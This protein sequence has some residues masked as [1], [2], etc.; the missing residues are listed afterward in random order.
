MSY[1]FRIKEQSMLDDLI[2]KLLELDDGVTRKL[3]VEEHGFPWHPVI[4][5]YELAK[6]ADNFSIST[7]GASYTDVVPQ[8]VIHKVDN[9]KADVVAAQ[10]V[11]DSATESAGS[12]VKWPDT[13]VI[14]DGIDNFIKPAFYDRMA[15]MVALGRHISIAGPPGIGKSTAIE[16][17]AAD[18]NKPM[19]HISADA[20][21]RR[22]DLTGNVELVNSHT[23]FMVAQ[24][25]AAAVFGWWVKIDEVN[26]AEPDALM[27]LNS[28]MAPPFT[29]NFYG[30]SMLV[31]PNFRLFVTYN[32][33]LIGTKPLPPA[34]K[35]RFFSLKMGF[36][37][38]YQ[39]R[40]LLEAN[41][42]PERDDGSDSAWTDAVIAYGLKAWEQHEKGRMRY[43][44]TPRRLMDAVAL[45]TAAGEDVF[46]AL[47]A[48]VIAAV[49]N[50]AEQQVLKSTLQDVKRSYEFGRLV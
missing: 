26:A 16:Q 43:Q 24:Y 5:A 8:T 6:Y 7:S 36:P 17:L 49:D 30:T 22:R 47:E 25:V 50:V 48:A 35:D 19:V 1:T 23:Q 32:P 2:T 10:Q 34:F 37:S 46:D 18:C 45:V 41:G 15:A 20:G 21:L 14:S 38:E 28:Q 33:G 42:M 40:R 31:H 27:F 39:L 9:V 12:T 44:I 13:P 11:G 29:V 4:A 3:L